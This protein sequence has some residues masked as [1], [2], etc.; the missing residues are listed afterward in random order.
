MTESLQKRDRAAGS[1]RAARRR[2]K[3]TPRSDWKSSMSPGKT[4]LSIML[5]TGI[6][7]SEFDFRDVQDHRRVPHPPPG[8]FVDFR[9]GMKF[10]PAR[11][12]KATVE[13]VHQ[14]RTDAIPFTI[15]AI[16]PAVRSQPGCRPEQEP[17]YPGYYCVNICRECYP[18]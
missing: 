17:G 18:D 12:G 16:W 1:R 14:I 9:L 11:M 8:P 4:I 7:T 6:N 2:E 13:K 3:E 10:S 15:F 5:I